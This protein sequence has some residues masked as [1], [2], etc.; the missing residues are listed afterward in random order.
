MNAPKIGR[1]KLPKGEAKSVILKTR[2]T[3]AEQKVIEQAAKDV[4][5][6]E[7]ARKVLLSAA[8]T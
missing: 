2:V 4:G 7:W 3:P 1:P 5:V 8:G 6:S